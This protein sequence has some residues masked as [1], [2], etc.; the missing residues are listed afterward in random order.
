M[1]KVV[2]LKPSKERPILQRH[3]WVFSG[4]VKKYPKDFENGEMLQVRSSHNRVLGHGYFNTNT[5]IAGRMINFSDTDPYLSINESIE[6]AIKLRY[7]LFENDNETN[8]Y[9][10]INGEGDFLP[11]LI[12]DRYN[13][14]LVVQVSTLGMERIKVL[15]IDK[16]VKMLSRKFN[17]RL[18]YEKSTMTSRKTEGLAIFEGVLW[19]KG[20]VEKEHLFVNINENG[21]KFEIDLEN[22][23]KTGFY[24]DQREM[25]KLIA[26][27]SQK[28]DLLNMFSYTG[29]FSVYA[30]KQGATVTSVDISKGVVEQA[31]RNFKLNNIDIDNHKFVS[32]DAFEYLASVKKIAADI[33][34]LDPPAFAKKRDDED[35]AIKGYK[36]LNSMA[37]QK[38]K[39]GTML[40]TCSCSYYVDEATFKKTIIE[41]GRIAK[42][43]IQILHTHIHAPDHVLNIYHPELDYL[44]S[45]LVFVR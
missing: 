12:V 25:R 38:M 1:F 20:N 24:L 9:R 45:L 30:A 27:F 34:I 40:L 3:H 14:V 17:L 21:H 26:Q 44:K 22:S 33:V 6:N 32:M 7:T 42:R 43:E 39:P 35:N 11:G 19:S 5:S 37:L 18:V 41:A 8:S 13:D 15:I 4:A 36:K 2:Y 29:G 31:Q 28:K 23:H 16:L 10:L